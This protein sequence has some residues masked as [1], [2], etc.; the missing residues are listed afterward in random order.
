MISKT[1]FVRVLVAVQ[2]LSLPLYGYG[3]YR[4]TELAG[5]AAEVHAAECL[6]VAELQRQVNTSRAFLKAT[7]VERRTQYGPLSK[8]PL[9]TIVHNLHLEEAA[10]KSYAPLRC[11]GR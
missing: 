2:L 9:P 5:Q 1:T 7:P 4:V 11:G 3:A 10:V 6:H 8:V